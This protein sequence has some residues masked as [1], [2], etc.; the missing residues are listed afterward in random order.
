MTMLASLRTASADGLPGRPLRTASPSFLEKF[1]RDFAGRMDS[2]Q[3][4]RP[5]VPGRVRT[6][7]GT[8]AK[9]GA[10]G[11]RQPSG[12]EKT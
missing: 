8:R 1:R 3:E 4:G 10:R 9:R 12:K 11:T 2:R 6:R 5:R 7:P